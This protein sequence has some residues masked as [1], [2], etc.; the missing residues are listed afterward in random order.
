MHKIEIN[1]NNII[2]EMKPLHGINNG[3]L[4]RGGSIDTGMF[5]KKLNPPYARLHD[6]HYPDSKINIPFLKY[7]TEYQLHIG[8]LHFTLL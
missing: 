6:T 1:F 3:P 2:G 5:Y 7:V 4:S 8:F